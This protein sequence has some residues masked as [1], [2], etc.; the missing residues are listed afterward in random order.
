[1]VFTEQQLQVKKLVDVQQDIEI[2]ALNDGVG[3][4]SSTMQNG[5][6]EAANNFSDIQNSLGLMNS[7]SDERY[8]GLTGSV[9]A[10]GN[11][12]TQG[13]LDIGNTVANVAGEIQGQL[14][15]M[16]S[17]TGNMNDSIQNQF[18]DVNNYVGG[19]ENNVN[20][21]LQGIQNT[22][23]GMENDYLDRF[24]QVNANISDSINNF[25][26]Q[27]TNELS[28]NVFSADTMI[29]NVS[30]TPVSSLTALG[31]DS[32]GKIIPVTVIANQNVVLPENANYLYTDAAGTPYAGMADTAVSTNENLVTSHA[33]YNAVN[34]VWTDLNEFHNEVSNSF[35]GVQNSF[36]AVDSTFAGI[37]NQFNDVNIYINNVNAG[38]Q[39]QFNDVNNSFNGVQNQFNDVNSSINDVRTDITELKDNIDWELEL[40]KASIRQPVMEYDREISMSSYKVITNSSIPSDSFT[41]V[42]IPSSPLWPSIKRC[43]GLSPNVSMREDSTNKIIY[44]FGTECPPTWLFASKGIVNAEGGNIIAIPSNKALKVLSAAGM[45]YNCINLSGNVGR[46]FESTYSSF[47]GFRTNFAYTFTN[48]NISKADIYPNPLD[49][50]HTFYKCRSLTSISGLY[51]INT[52]DFNYTFSGCG[53]LDIN[54][55]LTINGLS[56]KTS[57]Y[58]SFEGCNNLKMSGKNITITGLGNTTEGMF[59]GCRNLNCKRIDIENLNVNFC[60]NMFENCTSLNSD[61]IILPNNLTFE[62]D[63]PL[64][65]LIRAFYNCTSLNTPIIIPSNYSRSLNRT[66]AECNSLNQDIY[67]YSNFSGVDWYGMR[68]IFNNTFLN[69]SLLSTHNIHIPASVPMD[70]SNEL[71]YCL[72]SNLTGIDWTGRIYNDL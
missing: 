72:I 54:Y 35:G 48:T 5:F 14:N 49:M 61:N 30:A 32:N 67:I 44:I 7:L 2:D 41:A 24:N 8:N 55:D 53:N 26:E 23:Y 59:S 25:N 70:D 20:T 3:A 46:L 64:K 68:N 36:N 34:D 37:Q 16:N 40:Y 52:F 21:A 15:Q 33:V 29:Y 66:F 42:N 43:P 65:G 1:M 57:F 60:G 18:N 10:L 6:T 56:N 22:F 58:R 4:L 19:F 11:A 51:K 12:M 38:V 63:Y 39:N 31:Y 47:Y 62:K 17:N 27:I 69:C 9:N 13:F 45:F 28:V 50:N 71:Y